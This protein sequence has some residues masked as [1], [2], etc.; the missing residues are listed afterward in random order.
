[1]SGRTA[2]GIKAFEEEPMAITNYLYVPV[3]DPQGTGVE[4]Q[5][6]CKPRIIGET[7]IQQ[8]CLPFGVCLNSD[9]K[10]NSTA[11]AETGFRISGGKN[12]NVVGIG[13]RGITLGPKPPSGSNPS[14]NSC[15]S[16]TL[17]GNTEGKGTWECKRLLNPI[18]WYERYVTAQTK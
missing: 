17:I 18:R 2:G 5:D 8:F 15:G 16:L 14:P 7:D 13:I 6:P 4:V 9:G 11:E 10:K 12:L 1:V 3:Y